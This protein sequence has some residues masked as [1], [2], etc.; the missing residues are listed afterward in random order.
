VIRINI[1]AKSK[2]VKFDTVDELLIV[3]TSIF[4]DAT[5]C[6][7]LKFNRR[8]G[9]IYCLHLQGRRISSLKANRK[10]NRCENLKYYKL[11][12]IEK[13]DNLVSVDKVVNNF[14]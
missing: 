11:I 10:Q 8:F 9:G 1:S 2:F 13:T 14:A 5:P 4:W 6:S 7:P 12:F 3:K